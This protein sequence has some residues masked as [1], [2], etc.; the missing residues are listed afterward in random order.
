[1]S[2]ESLA[3][4]TWERVIFTFLQFLLS[5]GTRVIILAP[6]YMNTGHSPC[7]GKN[8]AVLIPSI[9]GQHLFLCWQQ[10]WHWAAVKVVKNKCYADFHLSHSFPSSSRCLSPL[11]LRQCF[12]FI[13]N[14]WTTVEFYLVFGWSVQWHCSVWCYLLWLQIWQIGDRQRFYGKFPDLISVSP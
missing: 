12:T 13:A 10:T 8:G 9:R 6:V 3:S 14:F 5:F 2:F 7:R 11:T 4:L 1:M